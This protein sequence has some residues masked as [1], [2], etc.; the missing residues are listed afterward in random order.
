MVAG[1]VFF[2]FFFVV[3]V[4]QRGEMGEWVIIPLINLKGSEFTKRVARTGSENS[5]IR[6]KDRQRERETESVEARREII[7]F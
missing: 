3:V 4:K 6:K 1:K 5:L 2:F 7:L